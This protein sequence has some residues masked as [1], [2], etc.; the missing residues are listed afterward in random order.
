MVKFQFFKYENQ[1]DFTGFD[2]TIL[3]KVNNKEKERINSSPFPAI[4]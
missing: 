1:N 2:R 3:S 4:A